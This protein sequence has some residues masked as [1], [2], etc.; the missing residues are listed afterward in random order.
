MNNHIQL[1]AKI[2]V[3]V[4]EYIGSG[5][6]YECLRT[7]LSDM[8]Y[9]GRKD[10]SRLENRKRRSCVK[11]GVLKFASDFYR[12]PRN[13]DGLRKDCKDCNKLMKRAR[14]TR[15]TGKSREAVEKEELDIA[16]YPMKRKLMRRILANKKRLLKGA[17][18][19]VY[20]SKG[21][22]INGKLD[23]VP[24]KVCVKCAEQFPATTDYFWSDKRRKDKLNSRCKVCKNGVFPCKWMNPLV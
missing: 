10:N 20:A 16:T 4:K 2:D 21:I 18:N 24:I 14:D 12:E 17:R 3:F 5:K 1:E 11:C 9:Y 19:A 22:I 23:K 15:P 6:D 8:Y 13:K 7:I